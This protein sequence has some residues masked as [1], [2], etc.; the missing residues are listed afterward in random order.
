MGAR[1]ARA[2]VAFLAL[3]AAV[4]V[5]IGCLATWATVLGVSFAGTDA[6]AGKSTLFAAIVAGALVL[7]G[8]S[9]R[10][11]WLSAVAAIPAAIA[12][13]I[14]S[15]RLADV[16]N[17]VQGHSNAEASWGIWLATISAIALFVLCV[18]HA[19][20]PVEEPP[21]EPSAEPE[22][23]PEEAPPPPPV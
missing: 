11:P 15:F 8:T 23:P 4:L 2:N 10:K 13:A 14:S 16:A 1:S 18:V 5:V 21:A 12:A 19:F 6:N 20:M 22:S 7:L 9:V 3:V 17:F